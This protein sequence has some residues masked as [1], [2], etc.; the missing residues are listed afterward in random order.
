MH[1][2]IPSFV[3]QELGGVWPEQSF[4]PGNNC[5]RW[6]SYREGTIHSSTQSS[7]LA[8]NNYA[9]GHY[10]GI[11]GCRRTAE[12]SKINRTVCCGLKG[13]LIFWHFGGGIELGFTSILMKWLLIE[14]SKKTKLFSVY[15]APKISTAVYKALQFYPHHS[16]YHR[17]L[18]LY[19]NPVGCLHAEQHLYFLVCQCNSA[20]L[21][22]NFL[23]FGVLWSYLCVFYFF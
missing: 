17:A 22:V 9:R 2:S 12:N 19:H 11:R 23:R 3:R 14:C 10:S 6:D 15:P 21:P 4:R 16:F 1:F 18:R 13:F 8:A 7:L 20:L 5:Y